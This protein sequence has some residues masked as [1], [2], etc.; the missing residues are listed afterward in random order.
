MKLTKSSVEFKPIFE[1]IKELNLL[2]KGSAPPGSV[3]CSHPQ[4]PTHSISSPMEVYTYMDDID[5]Y[6][7]TPRDLLP[8]QLLEWNLKALDTREAEMKGLQ[9]RIEQLKQT[10]A[11]MSAKQSD[12]RQ[13]IETLMNNLGLEKI[14]L[15]G[16]GTAYFANK[17]ASVSIYDEEL[18]TT[19][20]QNHAPELVTIAPKLDRRGFKIEAEQRLL[21][22]G[23]IIPGASA[24]REHKVLQIRRV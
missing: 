4:T 3:F 21:E 24:D 15:P 8:R 18:A 5:L 10:Y 20:A 23:E 19:W 11:V 7:E 22:T 2:Q 9:D 12:T 14:K 16:V 17:A 13:K 1:K 6:Q